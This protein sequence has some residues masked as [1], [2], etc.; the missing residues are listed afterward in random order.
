MYDLGASTR[1]TCDITTNPT[2]P[3]AVINNLLDNQLGKMVWKIDDKL[4]DNTGDFEKV[5]VMIFLCIS[6]P[7]NLTNNLWQHVYVIVNFLDS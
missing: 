6:Y 7:L 1:F 3:H 4:L 5:C 2:T